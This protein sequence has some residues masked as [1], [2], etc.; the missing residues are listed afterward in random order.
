MSIRFEAGLIPAII[1]NR[2]TGEVLMVGYMNQEA[3]EKTHQTGR[4]TFYSRSRKKLWTKGESS[5][6]WLRLHEIRMDCDGDALLALVDLQG[7]GTCHMG[8]R[9]CFFRKVTSVGTEVIAQQVF[10]PEKVYT[11]ACPQGGLS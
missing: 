9:S 10:E 3:Y 7:P 11:E 2:A 4:V 1:Q 5:G 6:H 8:Y